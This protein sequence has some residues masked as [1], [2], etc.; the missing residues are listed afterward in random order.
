MEVY[1]IIVGIYQK[2]LYYGYDKMTLTGLLGWLSGCSTQLLQGDGI[3]CLKNG[4]ATNVIIL[5][6]IIGLIVYYI[7]K[8]DG[9]IRMKKNFGSF[10]GK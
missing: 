6:I 9:K 5:L 10:A 1:I 2:H 4:G 7:K 3:V 8:K